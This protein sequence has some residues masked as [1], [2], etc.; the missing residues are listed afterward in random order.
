MFLLYYQPANFSTVA[1]KYT[2]ASSSYLNFNLTQFAQE[3][4]LG[5]PIAG[6]F[7]FASNTSSAQ[8]S[9]VTGAALFLRAPIVVAGLFGMVVVGALAV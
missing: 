6:N 2:N 9:P 8:P 3:V 5:S 1:P 7:F 4:G